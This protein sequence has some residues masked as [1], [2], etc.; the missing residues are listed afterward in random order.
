[1]DKADTAKDFC[2]HCGEPAQRVVVHGHT[3]CSHCGQVIDACCGDDCCTLGDP[4]EAGA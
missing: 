1:M 3:Q 2:P 4:D